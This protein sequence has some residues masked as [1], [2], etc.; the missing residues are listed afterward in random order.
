MEFTSDWAVQAR[1][2]R[3]PGD[4]TVH[5]PQ[6]EARAVD[7]GRTFADCEPKSYQANG[8]VVLLTAAETQI[9]KVLPHCHGMVTEL[10]AEEIRI[11]S[12]SDPGNGPWQLV[13]VAMA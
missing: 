9:V 11:A 7:R 12:R 13:D 6:W 2:L 5:A 10:K 1:G 3:H 4:S 8:T